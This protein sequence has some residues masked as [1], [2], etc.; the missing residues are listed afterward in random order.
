[1]KSFSK[2]AFV[3]GFLLSC[4]LLAPA[5]VA[6]VSPVV[7]TRQ[8]RQKPVWLKAKVV[9]F[10]QNSLTVRVVGD[11][12]RIL[13]FH[14]APSAQAQVQKAL[15][16]GGYPYDD[17]VRIRYVPGTNVALAIRGKLSKPSAPKTRK[18]T[19]PLR[20]HPTPAKQ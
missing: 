5:A 20:T 18:P 13:T 9:H 1:M 14:Y 11:E 6:Q 12:M 7:M 19:S 15:D 10:D 16:Q 3:L 4:A 17:P 2:F 8:A